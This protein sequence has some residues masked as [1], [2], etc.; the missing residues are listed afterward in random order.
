MSSLEGGVEA[1]GWVG[2]SLW[3]V[4]VVC[5]T[6]SLW[7]ACEDPSVGNI[8]VRGRWVILKVV[9]DMAH[10]DIPCVHVRRS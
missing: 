10:M 6:R 9:V 8:I 2:C 1:C 5:G 3:A 4:F 7:W